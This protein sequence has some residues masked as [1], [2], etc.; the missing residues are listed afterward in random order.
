ML[1][2]AAGSKMLPLSIAC[3]GRCIP[4]AGGGQRREPEAS[5][6]RGRE[7]AFDLHQPG[8]AQRHIQFT[9]QELMGQTVKNE[10]G[11]ADW[12]ARVRVNRPTFKQLTL[13]DVARMS[14]RSEVDGWYV[15]RCDS[16]WTIG[17]R[18]HDEHYPVVLGAQELTFDTKAVA[19]RYLRALLMPTGVEHDW[20]SRQRFT[21][22]EAQPK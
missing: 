13:N 14:A 18:S 9:R 2:T 4:R 15:A 3:R 16:K 19:E 20:P 21:I 5:S 11:A 8:L 22:T 6:K 10:N 17:R 7:E 1:V 12:T